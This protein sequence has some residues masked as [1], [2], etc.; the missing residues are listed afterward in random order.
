MKTD[1]IE[2]AVTEKGFILM[3]FYKVVPRPR[4]YARNM[5]DKLGQFENDLLFMP[6]SC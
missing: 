3:D 2:L 5:Q 4:I 6:S 1:I